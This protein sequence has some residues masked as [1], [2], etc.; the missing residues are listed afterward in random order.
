MIKLLEIENY[1]R[2]QSFKFDG[3]KRI[4]LITGANNIGKT[5]LL[6][7]ISFATLEN[8]DSVVLNLFQILQRRDPELP[9]RHKNEPVDSFIRDIKK[10]YKFFKIK[11]N[12]TKI[13]FE[14]SDS[15]EYLFEVKVNDKVRKYIQ[16]VNPYMLPDV[17]TKHYVFI[18][19]AGGS[20]IKLK[21]L[22]KYVQANEDEEFIDENI[23]LFDKNIEKFKIINDEPS[24]KIKNLND[25]IPIS[26]LGE[27][28]KRFI[29]ILLAFYKVKDK[30]N[31][32]VLID[33]IENGIWYKNYELV[34]KNIIYLSK[35]FD[36]QVF[37]TTHSKEL[38]ESF[39]KV[40]E[41]E[42]FEDMSFI[43]LLQDGYMHFDKDTL[44]L[45]IENDFEVRGW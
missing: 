6:E 42:N 15:I 9:I 26:E 27:G 19:D 34:W 5:S 32:L 23:R 11:S 39:V 31:S 10:R 45:E 8:P 33:E 40:I 43:E 38:I 2:L 41:K 14:S 30:K 44:K 20:I 25:Y 13:V 17:D 12:L 16:I 35:K 21:E 37:A 1:R 28:L 7:A 29:F 24:V 3:F 18:V 4:N 22:Y 36:V